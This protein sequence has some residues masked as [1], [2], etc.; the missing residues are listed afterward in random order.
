MSAVKHTNNGKC[1]KCGEI[2]DRYPNFNQ[3]LRSWFVKFQAK[4]PEAHISCAGRGFADQEAAKT[5]G[6][7][8]A[9]Y[10]QSAHNYNCAIDL[11][12]MDFKNYPDQLYPKKWFDTVL[13]PEVPFFLNWYGAPGQPFPELPH[14]EIREWRGLRAQNMASLVEPKKDEIA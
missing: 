13:A 6:A 10:G 1:L 12:V 11:F 7:S 4:H 9:S 8:R 14:L 5:A 2:F 3:Q